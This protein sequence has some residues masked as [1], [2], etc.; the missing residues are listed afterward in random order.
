[1]KPNEEELK[2]YLVTQKG[3]NSEKVAKGIQKMQKYQGSIGKT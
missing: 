2:E 3:F 1:V